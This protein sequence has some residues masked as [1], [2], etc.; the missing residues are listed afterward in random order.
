[1]TGEHVVAIA[2]T[3]GPVVAAPTALLVIGTAYK[4][5]SPPLLPQTHRYPVGLV[6]L[7]EVKY[8]LSRVPA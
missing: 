1:V 7:G 4:V 3:T 8:A 6:E 5:G 2:L